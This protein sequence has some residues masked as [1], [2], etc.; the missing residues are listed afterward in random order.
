MGKLGL[1]ESGENVL[2]EAL[3]ELREIEMKNQELAVASGD[4]DETEPRSNGQLLYIA[5][6]YAV[7][8]IK[9]ENKKMLKK[10]EAKENV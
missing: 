8:K 5:I 7:E 10:L 4:A 6:W 1:T 2:F 9:E 3:E